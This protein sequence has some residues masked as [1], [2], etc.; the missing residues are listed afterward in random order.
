MEEKRY[1]VYKHTSPSNKVYIGI[2]SRTLEERSGSRGWQYRKCKGTLI[3]KAIIK[4]GWSNFKHEI[5]MENLTQEEATRM[6]QRFIALYQ[7]N[8]KEYGYNLTNG[9]EKHFVMNEEV[10]QRLSL[11]AKEQWQNPVI[12]A[13]MI[14]K[15]K[16]SHLGIYTE[17][18]KQSA[19]KRR[20]RKITPEHKEKI[21]KGI[22]EWRKT[23]NPKLSEEARQNLILRMTGK[24][25]PNKGTHLTEEQKKIVSIRVRERMK[26][27]IVRQKVLE[28][29]RRKGIRFKNYIAQ[30]DLNGNLIKVHKGV[31]N[32][33]RELNLSPMSIHNCLK[34]ITKTGGGYTWKIATKEE[35]E[36]GIM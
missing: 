6:E 34:H 14:E 12:R 4:Y 22:R 20:G 10:K 9:G 21:M 13:N 15:L 11:K 2:T 36:N 18:Q 23:H 31:A 3:S 32:A 16:T 28:A 17:K 24:T 19:L 7:S 30:C 8:N 29:N 25:P 33:S 27:P 5:L 26:D 1:I 35:Y